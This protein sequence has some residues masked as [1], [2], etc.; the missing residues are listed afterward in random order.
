MISFFYTERGTGRGTPN[1]VSDAV[2]IR[3][4]K[5]VSGTRV[6]ESLVDSRKAVLIRSVET[7]TEYITEYST[8][9]SG[10]RPKESS[11]LRP[12]NHPR[13]AKEIRTL[14]GFVK[15]GI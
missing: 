2:R 11:S 14:V 10:G 7:N 15:T 1:K 6:K 12:A 9:Y 8:H 4:I 3:K 5:I 13:P